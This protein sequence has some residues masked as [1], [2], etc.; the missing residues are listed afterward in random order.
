MKKIKK[1][2]LIIPKLLIMSMKIEKAI[3]QQ[4]QEKC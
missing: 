1:H 3:I 2:S 4:R